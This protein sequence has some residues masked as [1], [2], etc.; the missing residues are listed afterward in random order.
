M[1]DHS[2]FDRETERYPSSPTCFFKTTSERACA[3][4]CLRIIEDA[5]CRAT[6]NYLLQSCAHRIVHGDQTVARTFA[7]RVHQ[8]KPIRPDFYVSPVRWPKHGQVAEV[9]VFYFQ[10]QQLRMFSNSG[11]KRYFDRCSQVAEIIDQHFH[12]LRL[13]RRHEIAFAPCFLLL[14]EPS[15]GIEVNNLVA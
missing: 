9:N 13:L 7:L 8:E 2:T 5:S 4:S 6:I 14:L 11:S 12:Q 3:Y 15:A 10:F 1:P